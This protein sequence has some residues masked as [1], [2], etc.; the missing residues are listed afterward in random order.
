LY[1]FHDAPT[2]GHREMNKTYKAIKPLYSWPNMRREIEEYIKK[3]ES[4]QC[5]K[6]L[7]PRRKAPMEITTTAE[8]PFEKSYLDIVGP[9]PET[10]MGNRYILT[11][12]DDLSKYV[13]GVPIRQQDAETIAREFVLQVILRHGAPRTVQTDQGSNFLS[14]MFKNTCKLLRIKKIQST[15]FH[16]ESQ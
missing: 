15:A 4:C 10:G 9:L 3:C 14:E 8:R 12:Q 5:N 7:K 13:I 16:P 1:E 6:L 11:F 2:G